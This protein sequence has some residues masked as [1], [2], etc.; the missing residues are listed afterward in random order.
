MY[1]INEFYLTLILILIFQL[2]ICSKLLVNFLSILI[3][4]LKIL[5]TIY[6]YFEYWNIQI[7][8]VQIWLVQVL[9][10]I[11]ILC[12]KEFLSIISIESLSISIFN[13][14]SFFFVNKF[15]I[16]ILIFIRIPRF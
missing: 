1:I 14:V 13:Y 5:R 11:L 15:K 6:T 16:L 10:V 3:K 4:K 12:F 9:I 7:I 8:L 2:R